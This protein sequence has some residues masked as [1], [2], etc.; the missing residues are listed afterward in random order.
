M[1]EKQS[2]LQRIRDCQSCAQRRELM[3]QY[4]RR[5]G[6][7]VSDQFERMRSRANI[8]QLN[9]ARIDSRKFASLKRDKQ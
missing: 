9:Q 8:E 5:F 3:A 4:A 2:L 6:G 7:F 1:D